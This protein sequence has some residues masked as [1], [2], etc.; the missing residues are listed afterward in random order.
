MAV[1]SDSTAVVTAAPADIRRKALRNSIFSGARLATTLAAG[2]CTSAVLA[3]SLGPSDTGFYGFLLW[4]TGVLTAAT[5][6][7]LPDALTKYISEYIGRGDLPRAG[8]IARRVLMLQTGIALLA[9]AIAVPLAWHFFPTPYREAGVLAMVMLVPQALQQALQSTLEGVQRYDRLSL[10][11]LYGGLIQ[12]ALVLIAAALHTGISG[13]LAAMLV[14]LIVNCWL[15]WRVLQ[16]PL[17][18]QPAPADSLDHDHLAR[19]IRNFSL[20]GMYAVLLDA[21]VWQRS[22]VLFL[23]K[24][25]PLPETAYYTLA[26]GLAA[27]LAGLA[28]VFHGILIPLCS[29]A[30]GRS[31]VSELPAIYR[32][33]V[34]YVQMLMVP[35]SL[36][37]AALA[38]PLVRLLYG[39]AYLP[40]VPVLQL[41]LAGLAVISIVTPNGGILF[42]TERQSFIIKSGTP[43]AILNVALDL[44]LIPRAGA[45]GAAVANSVAQMSAAVVTVAYLRHTVGVRFPWRSTLRIWASA[46]LA[47]TP[48]LVAQHWQAGYPGFALAAICAGLC[49]L[50]LLAAF[51]ELWG[52]ELE[53]FKSIVPLY[54]VRAIA[55]LQARISPS[56][57]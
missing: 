12:V 50:G 28:G 38:Q 19:R 30:F 45:M 25:S 47:V 57:D 10:L 1:P 48:L 22:E 35:L 33:A 52:R 7:G 2:V 42:A 51:R 16:A 49:Y 5:N 43:I 39:D 11:G 27:R 34:R 36:F 46:L 23:R 13:I 31:G 37:G 17:L 15:A 24:F 44:W 40:M 3:R 6:L 21:I 8:Q 20:V 32:G 55:L 29:E 56:R 41:L 4:V 53:L 9:A 18:Q 26:F 14:T 54:A